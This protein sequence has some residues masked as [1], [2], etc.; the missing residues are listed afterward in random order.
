MP[1]ETIY[2]QLR[3]TVF[4]PLQELTKSSF[5]EKVKKDSFILQYM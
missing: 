5:R 2:T 3:V 4:I 1:N